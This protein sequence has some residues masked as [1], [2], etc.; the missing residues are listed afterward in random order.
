MNWILEIDEKRFALEDSRELEQLL[1][2]D[3][4]QSAVSITLKRVHARPPAK[5]EK[6]IYPLLG[7]VIPQDE[8]RGT[9][10]IS[11]SGS[12]ALMVYLKD[13]S[14]DGSIG[15]GGEEAASGEVE[16]TTTAGEK[17]YEPAQE[18]IAR[19]DA[20]AALLE[21]YSTSKRPRA[22]TWKRVGAKI[23]GVK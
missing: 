2:S 15:V 17:F 5:W 12:R 14:D 11:V 6:I 7:L 23:A 20:I 1:N 13:D 10:E 3:A 18:C 9:I 22:I 16:F 21:F 8:P 4:G 19:A